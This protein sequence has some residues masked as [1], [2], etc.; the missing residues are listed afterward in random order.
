MRTISNKDPI[1]TVGLNKPI[2]VVPQG[3]K[4]TERDV[5]LIDGYPS[6]IIRLLVLQIPVQTL[7]L[8]DVRH[9]TKIIDALP[10]E[11]GKG[12]E[13]PIKL[14]DAEYDWLVTQ[15][16]EHGPRIFG[17]NA[18]RVMDAIEKTENKKRLEELQ[19][20]DKTEPER[21]EALESILEADEE[22]KT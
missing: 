20:D 1:L 10:H 16:E 11:S 14:D 8:I 17:M 18:A 15:A 7:K 12:N 13:E 9:G 4:E 3:T 2:Q 6:D 5:S 19:K 22:A 21:D